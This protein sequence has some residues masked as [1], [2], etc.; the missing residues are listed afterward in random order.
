M[1]QQLQMSNTHLAF[2]LCRMK[3]LVAAAS[4]QAS[5]VAHATAHV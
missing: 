4:D 1:T 2:L 5:T 3:L